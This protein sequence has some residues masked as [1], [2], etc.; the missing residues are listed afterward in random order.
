MIQ[1]TPTVKKARNKAIANILWL[2]LLTCFTLT[3]AQSTNGILVSGATSAAY[4]GTAYT[5]TSAAYVS[6]TSSSVPAYCQTPANQSRPECQGVVVN[7]PIAIQNT[8]QNTGQNNS[9]P[10]Y[11]S[12][13]ANAT[14]PE[15][16][17]NISQVNSSQVQVTQINSANSGQIPN[18]CSNPANAARPECQGSSY[19]SNITQ[20]Q[21]S[22]AP[23][24]CVALQY[25]ARPECQVAPVITQTPLNY[26]SYCYENAY[27][28]R[29]EC[30]GLYSNQ[31]TAIQPV[32]NQA[33]PAYCSAQ[34]YQS[35]P[36]CQPQQFTPI[37]VNPINSVR[38]AYCQTP[39]N[40]S[41][42]ECLG[43]VPTVPQPVTPLQSPYVTLP[44]PPPYRPCIAGIYDP[45]CN[46]PVIVQPSP[47][48]ICNPNFPST[49]CISPPTPPPVR[50]CI[51]GIYDPFCNTQPQP[52][53]PPGLIPVPNGCI[54]PPPVIPTTNLISP[55][56]CP[57][58]GDS[59]SG[60]DCVDESDFA[61]P[62]PPLHFACQNAQQT[63]MDPLSRL[64][65]CSA[66]FFTHANAYRSQNPI[67]NIRPNQEI[68]FVFRSPFNGFPYFFAKTTD[69]RLH[70]MLMIESP[71][72][73][74]PPPVPLIVDAYGES[75]NLPGRPGNSSFQISG[76]VDEVIVVVLTKPASD[77]AFRNLSNK[78]YLD[79]A[80]I[81]LGLNE[82]TYHGYLSYPLI[83]TNF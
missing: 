82:G 26:P 25:A 64:R 43:T 20:I 35:R 71:S 30:L 81:N 57:L 6:Q 47:P 45:L 75:L 49:N 14:R 59:T 37:V 76:F 77:N 34:Q 3:F 19:P 78:N 80:L 58:G 53:C 55:P 54:T 73:S 79:A 56:P 31:T 33:L 18:Y 22:N 83:P 65:L 40:Q 7:T 24:Y 27:R 17:T 13:P 32:T 23:S 11:C 67:A 44:T 2:F 4:D 68:S 70:Q 5:N 12:T 69:G 60:I 51:S 74:I 50:P 21:N 66:L 28:N 36:E 16:Q 29:T 38:P 42:P 48:V 10:S 39:A 72:P 1:F 8:G 15:C 61:L 41:R 9:I 52:P 63:P 62:L 46:T